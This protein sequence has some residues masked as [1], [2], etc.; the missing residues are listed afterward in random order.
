MSDIETTLTERFDGNRTLA[1]AIRFALQKVERERKATKDEARATG[2]GV[3]FSLRNAQEA[4]RAT[5][6][7]KSETDVAVA[8]LA[9]DIQSLIDARVQTAV[10]RLLNG[11][12]A[13][14]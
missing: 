9:D 3:G 12:S 13:A 1:Q 14:A 11:R 10:E 6:F 7:A 5:D 8:L 2:P 4:I